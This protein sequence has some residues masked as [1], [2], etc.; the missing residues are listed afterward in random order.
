MAIAAS[1]GFTTYDINLDPPCGQDFRINKETNAWD[2]VQKGALDQ[3]H[4]HL[5]LVINGDVR[6]RY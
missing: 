5:G 1:R 6:L 3:S 4:L 2:H